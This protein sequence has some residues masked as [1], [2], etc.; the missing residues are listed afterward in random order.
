MEAGNARIYPPD[1]PPFYEQLA[2]DSENYAILELP[3][4]TE[5]GRGEDTYEAYQALHHKQRFGGRLARDHKLTNPTNFVKKASLFH[6]FFLVD[7]REQARFY[8]PQDFLARTDYST[9]GVAILNFYKVRY[10]V[11]YKEALNE[12]LSMGMKPRFDNLISQVFGPDARPFFEDRLTKVYKVPPSPANFPPLTLDVGNGWFTSQTDTGKTYRWADT[13]NQ[14]PAEFYSMNLSQT[15]LRA[16]LSLKAFT[17]KTPRTLK[18]RIDGYE[19][20]NFQLRPEDGEKALSFEIS[21]PP[22][23]HTLSL[24]TPEPSLPTDDPSKDGRLLSFGV[25]D[26]LLKLL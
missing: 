2:R 5:K 22:G 3:L 21:I 6:D 16:I 17:F 1:W 7:P 13:A 19:A 20:A 12:T 18:V 26:V 11:I 14:Q 24:E 15:Q 8:P 25:Y 23:N 9:Q 4:F 10:L